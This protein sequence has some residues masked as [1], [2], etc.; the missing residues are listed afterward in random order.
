[1]VSATG[2]RSYIA[3]IKQVPATPR[4]VP[5]TPVMQKVN[6]V[7]EDMI[8]DIDT[9]ISEHV[10]DDRMTADLTPIGLNVSGGYNF[11][12]QY[13]NS[14]T[15]GLLAAFL[16]SSAWSTPIAG[17]DIAGGTFTLSGSVLD[18][19]GAAVKPTVV[20]GQKLYIA[21]T[22]NN[23]G[24]YALTETATDVYSVVPEPI[25]D[26]TF[27][28]GATATGSM[29]RNGS[30]YQPFFIERGHTDVAE[31]FKFIG[32]GCNKMTLNLADQSDIA[33]SYQFVGL[34][35]Q[36]DSTVEAGATY[37]DVTTNPIFSTS[38][39]IQEVYINGIP[40]EGCFVKEMTLEIDNKLTPK[41]GVSFIGACETK[42]HSLLVIGTI[43]M[44]F[45]D[46]TMY[47]RLLNGT[48]FSLDLV[49]LDVNG[50]GYAFSL[51][52]VKLDTDTVN[53][54]SVDTDVMD[55]ASY[56]ALADPITNCMI[57]IDKF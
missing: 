15:D 9:K 33:G 29:I 51:P 31:Y 23:D 2:S 12:F 24:V 47:T 54:T 7:S 50:N 26:E 22:V 8:T 37:T 25:A 48:A 16:W 53:V 6:F 34:T 32:M 52:R 18:L 4:V 36:V 14:L 42:A 11:E 55:N 57:Q 45:E 10:R 41:T 3:I 40:Q 49:I 56:V 30:F 46:S 13:E 44:Y 43:T 38:T 19:T 21:N 27:G 17:I 1:M 28:A 20:D 35:S 5:T 39:D